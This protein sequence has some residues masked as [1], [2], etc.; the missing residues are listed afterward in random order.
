MALKSATILR[1]DYEQVAKRSK[2]RRENRKCPYTYLACRQL[3]GQK[4][5]FFTPIAHF[6]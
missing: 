2:E 5:V 6:I 1:N 3:R 4:S